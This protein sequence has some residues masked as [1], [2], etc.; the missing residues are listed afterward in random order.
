MALLNGEREFDG[1]EVPTEIMDLR[2]K[3]K[4]KGEKR[5]GVPCSAVER[6]VFGRR[7]EPGKTFGRKKNRASRVIGAVEKDEEFKN[8]DMIDD[9]EIERLV[10]VNFF[11]TGFAGK[12]RPPQHLNEVNG[13][14]GGEKGWAEREPETAQAT[15]KRLQGQQV[16]EQRELVK[17]AARR[18][19]VFGFRVEDKE[20]RRKCEI[21]MNGITVEPSYAKGDFLIQWREGE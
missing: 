18:G 10:D 21:L 4:A 3:G 20:D 8:V 15:E 16:A 5:W 1:K 9:D 14:V 17:R 2:V 11:G 19:V 13:G 12:P 6:L 7:D